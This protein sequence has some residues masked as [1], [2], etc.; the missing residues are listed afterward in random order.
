ME[1]N[2]TTYNPDGQQIISNSI[3]EEP[4]DKIG[5][6]TSI[7][8]NIN[9]DYNLNESDSEKLDKFEPTSVLFG[10][11]YFFFKKPLK[12]NLKIDDNHIIIKN[13]N[14]YIKV[15]GSN[16]NEAINAFNFTFYSLYK[17]FALESDDKLSESSLKIKNKL[18]DLVILSI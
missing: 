5:F 1:R 17:N 18:K 8:E 13:N 10:D 3:I 16:I 2:I 4:L 7:I 14:L 11:K 6:N 9:I 15:W 12:C